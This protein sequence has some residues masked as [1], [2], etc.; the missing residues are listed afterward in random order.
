[1]VARIEGVGIKAPSREAKVANLNFL[2]NPKKFL[3]DKIDK[4]LDSY[5]K[6]GK[7]PF[8]T[9]IGGSAVGE[10]GL[11]RFGGDDLSDA[12]G[13]FERRS[14]FSTATDPRNEVK[15]ASTNLSGLTAKNDNFDKDDFN[16]YM[17]AAGI[18][19]PKTL[20]PT[21]IRMMRENYQEDKKEGR[22]KDG[23]I[24]NKAPVEEKKSIGEKVANFAGGV[25]NA[26]TGTQSAVAAT[27]DAG[28]NLFN[29]GIPDDAYG[30]T[31]RTVPAGSFG[32]SEAGK[33]QAAENRGKYLSSATGIP[34]GSNLP[35][36]SFGISE[37]GKAQAAANRKE[38]ADKKA[39]TVA[40]AKKNPNVRVSTDSRGRSKVTA[41][42]K[43]RSEAGSQARTAAG[44]KAR[45]KANA[46]AKAQAAAYNRKLSGTQPKS[47]K[48]RAKDAAKAR[49]KAGPNRKMSYGQKTRSQAGKSARTAAGNKARV[50]SN[51]RKR[52]QAAAKRRRAKKKSKK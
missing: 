1:M 12:S 38:V 19:Y 44:N 13:T 30:S 5:T 25:V 20:S 6:K 29:Q 37:K 31:E 40:R 39:A 4:K 50:K 9:N 47:A 49:K 11:G 42:T 24:I 21:F 17:G 48:Q 8:G 45:V 27:K 22:Y 2:R 52:A 51:A 23:Q 18:R 36:G 15:T 7:T 28:K 41:A 35:A 43:T 26:L 16:N 32:I 10:E 34:S 14:F 46:K 3:Q 33:E